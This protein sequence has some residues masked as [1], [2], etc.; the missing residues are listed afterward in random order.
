MKIPHHNKGLTVIELVF[1]LA[2]MSMLTSAVVYSIYGLVSTYQKIQVVKD[3]ERSGMIAM[4]RIGKELRNAT[5]I[6]SISSNSVQVSSLVGSGTRTVM[7]TLNASTGIIRILENGVD[8]GPLTSFNAS[9][10]RLAFFQMTTPKSKAVK[11]E[12]TVVASSTRY[13]ERANFYNTVTLRGSY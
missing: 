4:D 5:A 9:T 10:T 1:Y 13:A 12:M 2:I 7:F 3:V 6:D 8:M 11:I